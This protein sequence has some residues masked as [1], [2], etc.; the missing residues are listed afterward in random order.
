MAAAFHLVLRFGSTDLVGANW[1]CGEG[2]EAM[3]DQNTDCPSCGD[4]IEDGCLCAGCNI[5]FCVDCVAWCCDQ[6][7]EDCG[8]WFCFNSKG[9]G[10]D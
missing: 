4:D 7:D 8:D 6:D 2:A 1:V 9:K 10:D 3:T 5:V